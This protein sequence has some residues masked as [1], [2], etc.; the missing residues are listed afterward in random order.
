L[1]NERGLIRAN[2]APKTSDDNKIPMKLREYLELNEK[3]KDTLSKKKTVNEV[4]N[5]KP[6]ERGADVPLRP[7]NRF[8]KSKNETEFQFLNRIEKVN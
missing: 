8:K 2:Q 7:V 6:D 5:K 3:I 1:L 4:L